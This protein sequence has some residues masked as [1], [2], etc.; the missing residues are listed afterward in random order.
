MKDA[1]NPSFNSFNRNIIPAQMNYSQN[2][3]SERIN[4]NITPAPMKDAQNSSNS[5]NLPIKP[6]IIN[7]FLGDKSYSDQK[8]TTKRK[9]SQITKR[10]K[11]KNVRRSVG[12]R[13]K[14]N[15]SKNVD[16]KDKRAKRRKI[17]NEPNKKE[18]PISFKVGDQVMVRFKQIYIGPL[19][20]QEILKNNK[21]AVAECIVPFADL[22]A[23]KKLHPTLDDFIKGASVSGY[24]ISD[25]GE[26]GMWLGKII[27]RKGKICLINFKNKKI[28]IKSEYICLI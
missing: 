13:K 8:M 7:Q 18:L 21:Y 19:R 9:L 20:I 6:Y 27:S 11:N 12:A 14:S 26:I 1:Q 5:L 16:I 28:K 25:T 2:Y 3:S 15:R 17:S 24:N 23:Y 4:N 10:F 22:R